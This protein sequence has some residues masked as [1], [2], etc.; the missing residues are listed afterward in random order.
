MRPGI[1]AVVGMTLSLVTA[2]P[3]APPSAPPGE[4]APPPV[5]GPVEVT[6][7]RSETSTTYRHPNGARTVVL[8]TGP[9]RV[10]RGNGWAPLDLALH[11]DP[12]GAV[13]A[14]AH[15]Y[16]LWL[17]GGGAAAD[18]AS[19]RAPDGTNTALAWDGPLPAPQVDGTRATYPGARPGAD[20]VVEATRTGFVASLRRSLPAPAAPPDHA[21]TA[22]GLGAPA[23]PA[24]LVLRVTRPGGAA[25]L[26]PATAP[27]PGAGPSDMFAAAPALSQVVAN[28]GASL[29]FDTS[30]LS[31][32]AGSDL[33]SEPDLRVGS[34][35]VGSVARG[36]LSWDLS[37][38][39]G[40][41]VSSATLR[42]YSDWSASCEA[43]G[44]EV[45]SSPGVGPA[46]RWGNQPAGERAWAS[47]TETKGHDPACGAGW[48]SIDLTDLVR[49]WIQAGVG[50]GTIMVRA[51]D[52]GDPLSSKRFG[53]GDG[54][55]VPAL[56][57]TLEP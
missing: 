33:S 32:A 21:A 11:R 36:F 2:F 23:A 37:R 35:E 42:L 54:V 41:R 25:S 3:V 49:S 6:E 20:L 55:H 8:T 12:D 45:W 4:P 24:P 31:T 53:S 52:E 1:G 43:R 9:V 44:W 14:G 51:S 7:Q 15:P 50:V 30:V 27:A 17:S 29:P 56:G 38:L 39:G 22:S 5:S 48:V 19:V 26:H 18:A 57:I 13:R 34:Y 10:Q 40:E 47:S 28:G 46:T 16:L